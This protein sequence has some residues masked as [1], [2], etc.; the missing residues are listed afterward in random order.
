MRH[1]LVGQ[2][3]DG[4]DSEAAGSKPKTSKGGQAA[5]LKDWGGSL[6]LPA[7]RLYLRVRTK[8]DPIE[9]ARLAIAVQ[10]RRPTALSLALLMFII[11]FSM[12]DLR[13]LRLPAYLVG[14]S[15]ALLTFVAGPLVMGRTTALFHL[16][17]PL[18]EFEALAG[19]NKRWANLGLLAVAL[20]T[21]V[22]FVVFS[23]GVPPWAR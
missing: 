14:S 12:D 15:L 22:W 20:F 7:Q 1:G 2:K 8:A 4:G 5:R 18:A 11:G 10:S 23:S 3:E 6:F 21:V 19:R 9:P 13:V 17:E 16:D